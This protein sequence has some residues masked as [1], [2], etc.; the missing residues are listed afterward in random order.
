VTRKRLLVG[1]LVLV[2]LLVAIA[3]VVGRGECPPPDWW[4]SLFHRGGNFAC[5]S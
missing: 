1:V 2:V 5:I 3:Y 4:S